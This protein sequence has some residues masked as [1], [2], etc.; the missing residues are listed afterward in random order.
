MAALRNHAPSAGPTPGDASGGPGG[1]T[2]GMYGPGNALKL[3]LHHEQVK[4][5]GLPQGLPLLG[6]NQA[7]CPDL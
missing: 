7:A 1:L 2:S 5:L 3:A 4:G 6:L